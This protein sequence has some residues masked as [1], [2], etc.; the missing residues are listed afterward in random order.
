MERKGSGIPGRKQSGMPFLKIRRSVPRRT[1]LTSFI[2]RYKILRKTNGIPGRKQ[3]NLA[4]FSAT[5]RGVYL[6]DFSSLFYDE[7]F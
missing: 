7:M 5:E 2:E 3:E 6:E 4:T 1:F